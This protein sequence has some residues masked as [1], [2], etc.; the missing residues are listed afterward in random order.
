MKI[1]K[2][3]ISFCLLLCLFFLF[4]C[5]TNKDNVNKL[6]SSLS[7]YR[8]N[9]F[10]YK[11]NSYVVTLTSGERESNYIMNGEKTNLVDFGVLTLKFTNVF[12]GS[13]LQFELK[14]NNDTY[15]GEFELNPY[16]NSFVYDI[17][18]QVSDDSEVSLYL[19]DF[20]ETIKLNCL[21]K[22][23]QFNYKQALQIFAD[24]H[25][26]QI[27]GITTNNKLQGEIYIKTV[28]EDSNL[29]NI[30]WYVLL[31]CKNGEMYANLISVTTGEIMQST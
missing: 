28:A 9:L 25:K 7:E 18:K 5:G 24:N 11:N 15:A 14:I 6:E 22:N 23:W 3:L 19:I 20:D 27:E 17:Q 1:K 16:D 31:V 8:K 4:S 10:L 13:K 26:P 21:S 30:Y 29:S 12:A 2:V